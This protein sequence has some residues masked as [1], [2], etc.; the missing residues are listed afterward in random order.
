MSG[1]TLTLTFTFLVG[2]FTIFGELS[3]FS[4]LGG[5]SS[6]LRTFLGGTSEKIHP[7]YKKP[8]KACLVD[9]TIV[10]FLNILAHHSQYDLL[11]SGN[12]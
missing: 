12:F 9:P 3:H 5:T 1:Q 4:I 2:I 8:T 6:I 11:W 10:I 7:V